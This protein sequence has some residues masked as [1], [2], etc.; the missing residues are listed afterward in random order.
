MPVRV[1]NTPHGA[2]A[3]RGPPAAPGRA[4]PLGLVW[5]PEVG[6]RVA[7][8]ASPIPVLTRQER[9]RCFPLIYI[10]NSSVRTLKM[11]PLSR[12]LKWAVR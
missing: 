11:R 9:C 10:N 6:A 1:T 3:V 12:Q 4:A 2:R 5:S 7:V 8:G